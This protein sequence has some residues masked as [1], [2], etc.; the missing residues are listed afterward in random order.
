MLIWLPLM[1]GDLTFKFQAGAG[2]PGIGQRVHANRV[3]P[4]LR[5]RTLHD[6][7]VADRQREGG[8]PG[9]GDA[10][11]DNRWTR[12]LNTS[13]AFNWVELVLTDK[14]IHSWRRP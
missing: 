7:G 4:R 5:L 1:A 10:P 8:R 12:Y 2:S 13:R 3:D 14:T 9:S 6:E 11:A